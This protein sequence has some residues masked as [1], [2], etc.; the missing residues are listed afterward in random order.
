ME[1]AM[2]TD[3]ERLIRELEL[4]PHPEGGWYRETFRSRHSV[5]PDDGRTARAGLTTIDFLL[6]AGEVSR[7]HRV[8]SDEA[9]H[10]A[11][12]A[13]L[14][15]TIVDASLSRTRAVV[16]GRASAGCTP[17]HVVERESWQAARSLGEWTLVGCSVG[18]GFAFEDFT[19]LADVARE[20]EE[21]AR[22]FPELAARFG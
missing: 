22:R 2:N 12:G 18:P 11:D 4:T 7:F 10:F 8:H 1:S 9:W 15:L 6:V 16:L 20:R 19:L 14:E 5:A 3:A 13:P 21:L 17:S